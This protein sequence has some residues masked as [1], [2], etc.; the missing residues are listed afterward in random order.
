MLNTQIGIRNRET[1]QSEAIR[2][3]MASTILFAGIQVS[4]GRAFG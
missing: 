4:L 3:S 1:R 2:R